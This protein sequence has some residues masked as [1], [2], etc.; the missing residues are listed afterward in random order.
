M[1]TYYFFILASILL[2]V[3]LIITKIKKKENQKITINDE[4]KITYEFRQIL[5]LLENS[6]ENLFISGKAGTGKSTLLN[7]F[8]NTTNKN[9]VVLA[10]TGVAALN[11]K[12]RT[13][14]SFFQFPIK[15]ILERGDIKTLHR[16]KELFKILDII[17]IDEVSMVSANLMG[18]IDYSLRINKDNLKEP[19]GGVQMVFIGDLF[20][21]PPVIKKDLEVYY[22][23]RYGSGYFFNALVFKN[24]KYKFAELKFIFR[25]NDE[26]FKILLNRFRENL[27]TR[28]DF[29]ALNNRYIQN[30]GNY[31]KGG[32]FLT[33][34]RNIARQI[35]EEKLNEIRKKEFIFEATLTGKLK[36]KYDKFFFEFNSKKINSDE[37]EKKLENNF[38]TEIILKLKK[39]A[40]VIMVKNDSSRRWVNGSIGTISKINKDDV[41]VEIE[42]SVYKVEREMWENITHKYDV[43]KDEI[44]KSSN[45]AF[46]QYPIRLAYA[47]TIHK[48]QGKTFKNIVVDVGTG[49]FAHGQVYVALSRCTTLKGVILNQHIQPSDILVDEKIINYYNSLE[50]VIQTTSPQRN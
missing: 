33:T 26:E 38:P 15:D 44:I 1:P 14:H 27:A 18:T 2:I 6:N 49:A 20:Q 19:F 42:N 46:I 8:C 34:K 9:Y 13:L 37:Y 25:Q 21:L 7:H 23:N 35:N 45:G 24:F 5:D 30:V 22:E 32:V 31:V 17:I 16:Q 11:V 29:I 39:G 40:Q 48:S 28:D 3:I 47:L 43:V 12:G 41:W 36:E 10:P 50:N 4:I